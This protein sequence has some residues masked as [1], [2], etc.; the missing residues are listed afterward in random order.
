M[1]IDNTKVVIRD[2]MMMYIMAIS[3]TVII[4]LICLSD[5]FNDPVLGISRELYVIIICAVYVFYNLY[6]FFLNLNFIYFN[7]QSEKIVFK[8]YSLR[9]FMQKRRS[10]EIAKGSLM[11]FEVNKGL[12]SRKK[13]LVLFQKINNKIAKYPPISISALN[14]EEYSNLLSALNA[15]VSAN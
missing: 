13:N 9:P 4:P 7:D 12:I 5:Y 15:N 3:L 6:R 11:K 8:Y 1:V 2:R 10:I 14:S